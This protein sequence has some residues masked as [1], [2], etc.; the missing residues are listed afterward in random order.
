MA[1]YGLYSH[2]QSNRRRSIVLLAGLFFLVYVLVYAGAL[3]AEGLSVDADINTLLQLAWNDSLKA[4]PFATVGAALWI[5]IAYYFHQ[6]M[7]D[8]LTGGRE[9]ER[10]DEPRL[11]NILENLCISRG[12]P[13]PKLKIMEFRRAQCLR[14]RHEPQA[15]F[16]HRHH[17][18]P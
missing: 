16:H 17:R 1:A 12:I 13:T 18:T 4:A 14:H 6:D 15:I 7:I 5:V 8:A 11:Y 2:I 3:V 10:R 9:V